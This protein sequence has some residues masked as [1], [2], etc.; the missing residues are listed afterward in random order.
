MKT[1]FINCLSILLALLLQMAPLVR[2]ILPSMQ[3]LAPSNWAIILKLGVGATALFG[4]DAVSQASSISISP[5]NATVGQP[6]I[7]TITYS[8]GHSGSV[9]SM[10]YTNTCLGSPVPFLD[11][12]TIVYAGANAATVSGTPTNSGSFPFGLKVFDSSSCG[13]GGNSDFRTTTLVVGSSGGAA[14]APTFTASPQNTSAQVGTDVQ[15]SGGASGNPI[16]QYQWWQGLTPIPGATNSILTLS[17]IQ[18]TN[19]GV[20]TLTAS[21]SQTAGATFGTLPKANCYLSVAISGGTNFSAYNYTNFAPAGVP[22]TMF[23]WMTN[24]ST[25]TNYYQWLFNQVTV[26]STSNTLTIPATALTPTKSGTYTVILNSTNSGG[27]IIYG[28]NYDSY[29]AFGYPP[30]FTNSLPASSNVTASASVTFMVA[31]GGSLNVY[32]AQNVPSTNAGNPNVFW[33]QNG[34]QVAAQSYVLNPTSNTTYS[35]NTTNV[36]LTLNNVSGADAGNYT[37]V[38]TNFWGSITSSPVA[39]TVGGASAY[40]PVI[41]MNPP[42][43][44]SLLA[45]QSTNI[46][47]T[48]TGTPPFAY[49]WRRNGTDL[50]DGTIYNGALTNTLSLMAVN[51]N[52]SGNYTVAITNLSGAVTSSVASVN[53]ALPPL[54]SFSLNSP[55]ILQFNAN[56]V[57]GLTYVVETATNLSAPVW[58]P[59]QTNNTGLNGAINFRTNTT[60]GPVKFYRLSFP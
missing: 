43:L 39:L 12:M 31:V 10:S 2:S 7:G 48:V 27:A 54:V 47:V 9:R 34:N 25:A 36:S 51:P 46:S 40:A 28:Q 26:L 35:K 13:T 24:V 37:V 8:G 18:L 20:Y 60:S 38:I 58:T 50:A 6:Y 41:A 42:A 52:V 30:V 56:T 1:K 3:G 49:Q 14:F 32:Y 57:T 59:L 21:N 17:N 5:A 55:G 19:S 45:G 29:W 4:F 53:I 11:G 22:L 44:V 16:P 15:L 33:Y 23:S